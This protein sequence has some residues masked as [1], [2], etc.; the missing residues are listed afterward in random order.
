MAGTPP[1]ARTHDPSRTR[2]CRLLVLSPFYRIAILRA[3]RNSLLGLASA[4]T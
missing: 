3:V 1:V 4:T 2:T